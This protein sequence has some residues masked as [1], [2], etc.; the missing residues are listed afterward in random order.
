MIRV[1]TSGFSFQDWKGTVYP[2]DIPN[3]QMLPF[4]ETELGFDTVEINFTYYALPSE[5]SLAALA[6]KTS[7]G[8]GFSVKA[9][10][11]MT[12]DIRDRATGAFLDNAEVFSR[13]TSAL[14]PLVA[15]GKLLTVL[16]QFPYVFLPS[17]ETYDYLKLFRERMGA[18]P[19]VVEFRNLAWHRADVLQ[20]LRASDIGYC[21][22]DEPKLSRLMPFYPEA[23]SS[24]GYFRLHGRN[25]NWFRASVQE[26]YDYLYSEH[27]L[28]EF[29]APVH[30]VSAKADPT[31]VYFNNC[32]RGQAAQNAA[33]MKDLLRS[34]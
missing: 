14:R 7:P 28:T 24:L 22:V 16:A 3:T 9:F 4:Y 11:G 34:L 31:L 26:R 6:R 8:F 32:H 18:L 13:F 30:N 2:P 27:E 23:T 25:T 21:V 1:G 20:F 33:R 12:H 17:P 10:K 29:I 5:R 19:L 15:D